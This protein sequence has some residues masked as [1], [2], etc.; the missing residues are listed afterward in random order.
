MTQEQEAAAPEAAEQ[1]GPAFGIEKIYVKDFSLEVPNAPE[2]FLDRGE[3]QMEIQLDTSGTHLGEN[4]YNAVLTVRVTAKIGEKT[5]FLVEVSQAGIFHL[6]NIPEQEIAPLLAVACPNIL[7]PYA[8][9]AISDA[10]TRAG[11]SPVVLQPLNFD[12]LYQ[13][14]L[15]E[16]QAAAQSTNTSSKS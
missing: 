6:V 11:F 7:Q 15:Q 8:R 1:Q 4:L 13:S 5:M 10:T 2:I 3:P 12:V 16:Q 14:R 9:E